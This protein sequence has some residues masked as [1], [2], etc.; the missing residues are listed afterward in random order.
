MTLPLQDKTLKQRRR[1]LEMK[2]CDQRHTIFASYEL[3]YLTIQNSRQTNQ[4][5]I[6]K[7]KLGNI[8]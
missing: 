3:I 8:I 6:K 2:Q 7:G 4:R 1:G 5:F